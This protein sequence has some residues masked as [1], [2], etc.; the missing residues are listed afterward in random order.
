MREDD[1]NLVVRQLHLLAQVQ[2]EACAIFI[3]AG[4]E[5]ASVPDSEVNPTGA[6]EIDQGVL[7]R[8]QI[9]SSDR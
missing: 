7:G 5:L 8:V 9:S 3:L 1:A 4:D 6:V 2:N